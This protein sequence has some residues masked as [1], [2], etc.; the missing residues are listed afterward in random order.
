MLGPKVGALLQLGWLEGDDEG[1]AERLGDPDGEVEGPVDGRDEGPEEGALL[2]LGWLEGDD[3]GWA[4]RLGDPD[5][6]V[7]G[8]VDGGDD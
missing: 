1:W 4:E 5:G 7:E 6:E 8:P 3:E 2:Q